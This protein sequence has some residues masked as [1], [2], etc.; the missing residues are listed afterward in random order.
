[1]AVGLIA[2]KVKPC[3]WSKKSPPQGFFP[4]LW[5]NHICKKQSFVR[6]YFSLQSCSNKLTAQKK[7][8][9][10]TAYSG[11]L[12]ASDRTNIRSINRTDDLSI[13]LWFD[14][15]LSHSFN[16]SIVRTIYLS[17]DRT[18]DMS[19]SRM[20]ESYLLPYSLIWTNRHLFSLPQ[21]LYLLI[22]FVFNFS[23]FPSISLLFSVPF[24]YASMGLSLHTT[25]TATDCIWVC[26]PSNNNV[27]KIKLMQWNLSSSTVRHGSD[28]AQTLQ[29]LSTVSNCLSAIR[30]KQTNGST[31]KPYAAGS[32]SVSAP[33]NPI[34]IRVKYPSPSLGISVITRRA[35]SRSYWTQT[36]N[37]FKHRMNYGRERNH[38]T[39]R[40]SDADVC[41]VDG[42]YIE[43]I[44]SLLRNCTPH[45]EWRGLSYRRWSLQPVT[46]E[47]PYSSG[48]SG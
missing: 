44:G 2:R 20:F 45:V 13:S 42:G 31:T 10:N 35:T 47:S 17:N 12:D 11:S 29:I 26:L 33:C 19:N 34:A 22:V 6:S 7:C 25:I 4:M 43:E 18:F 21:F 16:I 14:R 9:T 38:Y 48:L 27:I 39:E 8:P 24:F 3:G 15:E 40:P 30:P 41:T 37:A 28:T 46:V 1:M 23:C 5:Y 36:M 32:A